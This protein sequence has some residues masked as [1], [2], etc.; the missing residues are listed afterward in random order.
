MIA[1]APCRGVARR[2]PV[3][4]RPTGVGERRPYMWLVSLAL[5]FTGAI[6][7]A[8]EPIALT[9][10]ALGTTW[11]V[12]YLQSS[13][14][15][16][17]ATLHTRIA[18]TLARLEQQFSTY[19][20]NSEL[21]RFN[22]ATSTEWIT[23]SPELARVAADS[24]ALSKRTDGA[25]DATVAPL[26][27]LWGFGPQ[28]RTGPPP[29]RAEVVT[30]RAR[31]DYRRLDARLKP[32]A[33]R[34]ASPDVAADFSSMAKGFA[35]DAVS[36]LLRGLGATNHFVQIG[37]DIKTG[38]TLVWRVAIEQPSAPPAV[39]Q[40]LNLAGQALSTSGDAHNFFEH[41]GRR[42]GHIIDP[43][44]GEPATGPL[45]AVSVV[46]DSC[47]VSSSL[48]TALFV[49]GA[50]AGYEFAAR[51]KIAALFIVRTG[52]T[53]TLRPTPVFAQRFSS[54]G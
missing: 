1:P 46:H 36:E 49:L 17:P 47:A 5:L 13:P 26:L 48:A 8:A 6:A 14:P 30:A 54:G 32:P 12:K 22:S 44:M 19:R 29:A 9:G 24:R 4:P 21:S 27:I 37:G 39:A 41:A 31:I 45:A 38:G 10:R 28:R 15:L 42:Y 50:E 40:T 11:T 2:R 34:K 51:E 23:V 3:F 18:E 53:L 33:L 43:R 16:N 25:F 52:A 35:A 20:P 7:T